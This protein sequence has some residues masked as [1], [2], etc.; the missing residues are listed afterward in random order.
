MLAKPVTQTEIAK[1]A[2][3]SQ[4]AVAT[5]VGCTSKPGT[6]VSDETRRRIL[7][8]AEKMGYRPQRQ[9]QFLR[10]V[11]SGM[12]GI[13]KTITLHQNEVEK[14]YH[15]SLAIH[16]AGYGLL[17]Q[18]VLWSTNADIERA[19]GMLLDTRVEGILLAGWSPDENIPFLRK[20]GIPV[21]S[22]SGRKFPGCPFVDANQ[23]QG[24]GDLVKH[25]LSL[26]HRRLVYEVE[27]SKSGKKEAAY[28]STSERL[29]G[30]I[31]TCAQAGLSEE[32]ARVVWQPFRELSFDY[33]QSGHRVARLLLESAD[34]PDALICQNDIH[35]AGAHKCFLENGIDVPR[36]V[37]LVGYDNTAMGRYLPASLTSVALPIAEMANQ[38]VDLLVG[39]IRGEKRLDSVPKTTLLPCELVVRESC[40]AR[41]ATIGEK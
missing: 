11:K 39:L 35:A 29:A 28:W 4:R 26:G 27:Q 34:L 40:G 20:A 23:R 3:V 10:G 14:A 6:R 13:M 32:E 31:E 15:A 41:L 25:L 1:V 19:I 16:R 18:E 12:I 33:F 24:M 9:A 21:V 8:V 22:L 36:D 2:G 17:A 5:V 7:E 30:F 37:A 38:A